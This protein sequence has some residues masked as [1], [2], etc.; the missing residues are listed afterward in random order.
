[1][2]N[3]TFDS[4]GPEEIIERVNSSNADFVQRLKDPNRATI[5]DWSNPDYVATHKLSV[6][7]DERG[8]NYIYPEGQNIDGRLVDF[9]RP[10][11]SPWIGMVVA[12]E[13]GDTVRVDN[14]DD[15]IKFTETYKQYYPS[16]N[17]S[18]GGKIHIKPE[19]R[20]KFTALKKRTGHSAS[21]F[22]AHGTPA[23]RK[24]ATFALNARKWKHGEGGA[25][26]DDGGYSNISFIPHDYTREENY[27]EIKPTIPESYEEA[28]RQAREGVKKATREHTLNDFYDNM[29]E[30]GLVRGLSPRDTQFKGLENN[31]D[32][33][34]L[35][36][37]P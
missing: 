12:E 13:R 17:Y 23:Q 37:N 31:E 25:L 27:I 19:N 10:P 20:G 33:Y 6:G 3:H 9:T 8:N 32:N 5:Q 29:R 14:L 28:E 35:I 2:F 16:F 22:K 1:M 21:W 15:A 4:G 30:F 36:N 26:F 34:I 7:T 24:M 18:S 11:Y